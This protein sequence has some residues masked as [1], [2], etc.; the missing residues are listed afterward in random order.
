MEMGVEESIG[1]MNRAMV[2]LGVKSWVE[3][4]RAYVIIGCGT[5]FV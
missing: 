5:S 4:R 2:V 3:V 1:V